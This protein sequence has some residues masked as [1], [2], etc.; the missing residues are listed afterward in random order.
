[1]ATKSTIITAINNFLVS[2]VTIVKVKG[3]LNSL[4]NEFYNVNPVEVLSSSSVYATANSDTNYP[5]RF[6]FSKQGGRNAVDGH[7]RN[8]TSSTVPSLILM[9][10]TDPE[11]LVNEST[12]GGFATGYYGQAKDRSNGLVVDFV[13]IKELGVTNFK[14]LTPIAPTTAGYDIINCSYNTKN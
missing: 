6:L 12:A 13:I 3:A 8:A 2:V 9:T 14:L 7:F 4:L 5:Y 10:I 11:F 1:M